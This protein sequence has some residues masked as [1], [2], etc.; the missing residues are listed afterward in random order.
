MPCN[1]IGVT[2]GEERAK[3]TKAIGEE[4]MVK[5]FPKQMKDN[6]EI[7]SESHQPT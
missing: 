3:V 6:A 2:K 4:I 7:N 5:N 1:I